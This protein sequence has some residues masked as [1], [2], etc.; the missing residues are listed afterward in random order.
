[1]RKSAGEG[2]EGVWQ[3]IREAELGMVKGEGGP[4]KLDH[5]WEREREGA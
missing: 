2:M 1:M 3:N 4:L 5:I